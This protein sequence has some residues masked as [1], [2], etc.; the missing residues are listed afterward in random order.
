MNTIIVDQVEVVSFFWVEAQAEIPQRKV[1]VR[2]VLHKTRYGKG[3]VKREAHFHAQGVRIKRDI[4][5][6]EHNVVVLIR[7]A[8]LQHFRHIPL[9]GGV[10]C[11]PIAVKK[12]SYDHKISSVPRTGLPRVNLNLG[13]VIRVAIYLNFDVVRQFKWLV[14][15]FRPAASP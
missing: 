1:R 12:L 2:A 9:W 15:A 13:L 11:E 14:Q 4:A 5:G 10:E 7:A 3:P 8:Q 6:I